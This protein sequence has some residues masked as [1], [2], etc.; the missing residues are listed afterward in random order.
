MR[1]ISIVP[2]LAIPFVSN[3]MGCH[4]ESM[5]QNS[6]TPPSS[7]PPTSPSTQPN[8]LFVISDDQSYPH[9]TA[10]GSTMVS[11][12]GFDR[13]A[14]AGA[15]FTNHYVTSPGSSPSR[16]SML[17][18]LY[19]WQIEEA[20][21]HAS[22]F[23]AKYVCFPDVLQQAGYHIG[24]T[25]KGW[26]PGD[27][28]GSGRTHN[29]AGP[30]YN[31]IQ[32]TPPYSGI[33]KID[34][35]A[36]FKKFLSERKTG[37]PFYFWLGTNEPHRSYQSD[38]WTKDGKSLS[39]ASVPEY[40]PDNDA[41]KGD[42]LNYAV[43]IEWF[44]QHLK[45][46]IEELDRIGE[47]DNTIIIVTADNGMPFPR[48]KSNC[49]DQGIHVPLAI[50]WGSK[51]QPSQVINTLTSSVD[52]FPTILDAADLTMQTG[53]SGQSLLPLICGNP[54]AYGSD[55]V[56]AGRERHSSARYNNL[57][58]PIRSVRWKD[59]LLVWNLHPERWPAGDPQELKNGNPGTM[60]KAYYDIDGSP[61]KTYL[62]DNYNDPAVKPYFD[63]AVAKRGEYELYDLANDPACMN[64][65]AEVESY[66]SILQTLQQKLNDRLL[67]TN[68][69]RLGAN[70]DIWET[71]PRLVGDIRE[72]PA[73][74][75]E[76]GEDYL[77]KGWSLTTNLDLFAEAGNS[78]D[79]P[80][81][82]IAGTFLGLVKPGKT[83]NG[84][85]NP[86]V[87]EGGYIQFT[88]DMKK[89][90]PVNYF[91][92]RH[93]RTG[94][95]QLRWRKFSQISGSN[96]GEHFTVIDTDVAVTGY[97]V[98]DNIMTPNIFF[99]EATYRYLRFYANATDCWDPSSGNS[100][101]MSEFYLGW[102]AQQ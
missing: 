60:H 45:N 50:C 53:L 1:P 101:Q 51:I 77:R 48:A 34:Y 55:A 33:S 56:Y 92:I 69:T 96:D 102:E 100:V 35:T 52:F 32:L 27:W 37:Q 75:D 10:Y 12:P 83:H 67:V 6:N 16:A 44:D 87:N 13:V 57:G 54:E 19:P 42:L 72:F 26:S 9:S 88:I 41:V 59:Y 95:V 85:S 98:S 43:E 71:Y 99:K 28:Q 40:L 70:P 39:Q 7:P 86:P 89:S 93:K 73:P 79:G 91:R 64:D 47:F 90:Q 21:T 84:I 15:L 49:Y 8:I 24:Y 22:S 62:T 23:P 68:D 2:L 74:A 97:D 31:D 46:C 76:E 61:S 66:R 17:T 18:G 3:V 14:K 80:F 30:A 36:N 5:T 58:Y 78:L 63:A 81:D 65:L 4:N 82:G 29:P 11:T 25:G 94:N 20:G 38:S